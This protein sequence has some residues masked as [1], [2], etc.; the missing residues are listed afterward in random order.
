DASQSPLLQ[1]LVAPARQMAPGEKLRYVQS[2]VHT[3][4]RWISDA[5]EWGLHDYW[6]SAAETLQR[7]A[8]DMEDRAIVKMQALRTL[9][10]P[11]RDLYL[12]MGR[13]KV[14]GPITVLL[15]R[16]GQRF[17][18]LDDLGGAPIAAD[19][20]QGFEPMITL[21]HNASWI[22]GHRSAGTPRSGVATG[23]PR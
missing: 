8:G 20:R 13:D 14:G 3:S 23:A 2:R 5:T 22:H 17:F 4:I 16:L 11:T 12:T 19:R 21:G 15:V 18:V 6:A 10:F 7:G 9:G 1:R